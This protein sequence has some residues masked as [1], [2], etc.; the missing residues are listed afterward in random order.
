LFDLVLF[1]NPMYLEYHLSLSATAT[2]VASTA[3][4]LWNYSNTLST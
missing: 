2:G 3:T 1:Y 4:K